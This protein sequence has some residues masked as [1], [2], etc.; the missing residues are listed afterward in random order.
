MNPSEQTISRDTFILCIH[1]AVHDNLTTAQREALE[2]V[3]REATEV[4]VGEYDD[5]VTGASCPWALADLPDNDDKYA[6]F[7]IRFDHAVGRR[8]GCYPRTLVIED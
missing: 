7:G 6:S 4:A 5:K 2:R 1:D 8:L 3:G